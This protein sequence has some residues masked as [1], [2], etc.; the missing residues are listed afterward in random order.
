MGITFFSSAKENQVYVDKFQGSSQ[1]L[2][3]YLNSKSIHLFMCSFTKSIFF[4]LIEKTWSKFKADRRIKNKQPYLLA[5]SKKSKGL[6]LTL[7]IPRTQDGPPFLRIQKIYSKKN[8]QAVRGLLLDDRSFCSAFAAE[9]NWISTKWPFY[10]TVAQIYILKDCPSVWVS[11][12]N[13][14]KEHKFWCLR[15]GPG[16]RWAHAHKFY[17]FMKDIFTVRYF[18]SLSS[19]CYFD[20]LFKIKEQSFSSW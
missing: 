8:V 12:L 7:T 9:W 10:S 13:S 20:Q 17:S 4:S 19:F 11:C 14:F 16:K 5:F 6:L 15:L 18:Q 1:N 3:A 2:G